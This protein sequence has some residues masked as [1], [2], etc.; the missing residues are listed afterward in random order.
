M[1][2]NTEKI[3]EK[4]EDLSIDDKEGLFHIF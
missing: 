4:V 2:E 1:S 3:E